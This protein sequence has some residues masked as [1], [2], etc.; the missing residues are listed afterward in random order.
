MPQKAQEVTLR[1]IEGWNT[2]QIASYLNYDGNR[3][4]LAH[5]VNSVDFLA[6]QKQFS[7]K[8]YPLLASKPGNRFGRLFISRQLPLLSIGHNPRFRHARG[9]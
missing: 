7:V 8:D 2:A 4:Q 1:F 3:P 6:A 9:N 5:I